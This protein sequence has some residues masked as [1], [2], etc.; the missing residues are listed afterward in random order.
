MESPGF[1][2]WCWYFVGTPLWVRGSQNTSGKTLLYFHFVLFQN[3]SIE[4]CGSV[5][6][7]SLHPVTAP[8]FTH[9]DTHYIIH[10]PNQCALMN[11]KITSRITSSLSR[12]SEFYCGGLLYKLRLLSEQDSRSCCSS[13]LQAQRDGCLR[14]TLMDNENV[15]TTYRF[16]LFCFAI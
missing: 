10:T 6:S 3:S 13:L 5:R 7:T 11:G 16:G 15:A 1:Q 2:T 14:T 8:F 12:F 9:T 4:D